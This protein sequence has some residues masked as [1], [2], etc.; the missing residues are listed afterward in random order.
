MDL[1]LEIFF[2]KID[3]DRIAYTKNLVKITDE[4]SNPDALVFQILQQDF[5]HLALNPQDLLIHSTSWRFEQQAKLI[6]TYL[7]YSEKLCLAQQKSSVLSIDSLAVAKSDNPKVPRPALLEEHHIISHAFRHL[8][9]LAKN[10]PTVGTV[11]G[12]NQTTL[13]IFARIDSAVAGGLA[14]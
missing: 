4:A 13:G 9:F 6:I 1:Y 3:G 11:L 2:S 14:V 12:S 7:V 10:D 5:P 8:S